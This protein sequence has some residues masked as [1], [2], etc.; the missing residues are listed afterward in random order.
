MVLDCASVPVN[1]NSTKWTLTP[2][3]SNIS[4]GYHHSV[5]RDVNEHISPIQ[6]SHGEEAKPHS[7]LNKGQND[8]DFSK[9]EETSVMNSVNNS[10]A[11]DNTDNSRRFSRSAGSAE[12]EIQKWINYLANCLGNRSYAC[13]DFC[14]VN[15]HEVCCNFLPFIH[16]VG[17]CRM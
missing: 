1:T 4:M 2:T 6:T 11:A 10:L 7:Y 12:S 3:N 5:P 9:Y 15:E 8:V 14:S 16:P 13:Q 17:M